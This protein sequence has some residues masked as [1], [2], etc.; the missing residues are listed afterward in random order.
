MIIPNG[1]IEFKRKT[2]K[3]LDAEGFPQK[4]VEAWGCPVPCQFVPIKADLLARFGGNAAKQLSFS[5]YV[6]MPMTAEP[7]EELRLSD[8]DRKVIGQYSVVSFET[9]I[10]VQQIVITV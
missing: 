2:A 10:A 9:L 7:T 6:A 1:F 3:G 4:A 5:L 8:L